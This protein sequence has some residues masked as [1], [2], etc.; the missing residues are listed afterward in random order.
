MSALTAVCGKDV[1]TFRAHWRQNWPAS[2][3]LASALTVALTGLQLS[4]GVSFLHSIRTGL[5]TSLACAVAFLPLLTLLVL[6]YPVRVDH[7][8]IRGFDLHGGPLSA[9]WEEM[10]GVD[11]RV[12]YGVHYYG[13]R[14]RGEERELYLAPSIAHR[15]EFVD[16]VVGASNARNPLRDIVLRG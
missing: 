5:F 6:F 14:V 2:I 1:S 4:D 13:V 16:L 3:T 10:V 8:G 9:R 11:E 7:T 15:T 12:L